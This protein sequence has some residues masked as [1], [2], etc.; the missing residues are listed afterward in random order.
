V[1]SCSMEQGYESYREIEMEAA[2]AEGGPLVARLGRSTLEGVA[3]YLNRI[4]RT[5]G[6]G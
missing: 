3:L 4:F 6:A 1:G 5:F 2:N